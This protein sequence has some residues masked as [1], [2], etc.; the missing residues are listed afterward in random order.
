MNTLLIISALALAATATLPN[1]NLAAAPLGRRQVDFN[2]DVPSSFPTGCLDSLQQIYDSAPPTPTPVASFYS[3]FYETASRTATATNEECAWI[4][5]MPDDVV[6]SYL[7]WTDDFTDW[8]NDGENQRKV[9]GLGEECGDAL[10][11]SERVFCVE[12]WQE[13]DDEAQAG[14]Y[15]PFPCI[16]S[17]EF[18]RI[19][20]ERLRSSS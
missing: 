8:S 1:P 16:T 13:F 15:M 4:T 14:M 6:K 3:A 2:P 19:W 18:P 5:S 7:D 17:V 9:V 11:G 12:E 10:A 20:R